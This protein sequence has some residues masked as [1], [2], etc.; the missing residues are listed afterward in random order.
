[1]ILVMLGEQLINQ[2]H[3]QR[4]GPSVQG[5]REVVLVSGESFFIPRHEINEWLD[6]A[7]NVMILRTGQK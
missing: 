4:I 7:H 3:I 6:H 2:D 1:M 5:E